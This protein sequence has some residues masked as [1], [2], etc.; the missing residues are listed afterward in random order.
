M[1][2][3]LRPLHEEQLRD[4]IKE[5]YKNRIPLDLRGY[6]SKQELG[7]P[8]HADLAIAMDRMRSIT[9]YRPDEMI[10][11]ALAGTPL[12]FIEHRLYHENQELAF[13]PVD[14][15]PA[16]GKVAGQTSIGAVF[17]M[18]MSGSRRIRAGAARDHLIGVRGLN[19]K[20]DMINSGGKVLKNVAGMDMAKILCGSW[21]TLALFTEVTMRVVPK[22]EESR[23]LFIEGLDESLGVSALTASINSPHEVTGTLHLQ[24]GFVS[25]LSSDELNNSDKSL[26][27]IRLEGFSSAVKYHAAQLK[28]ELAPFGDIYEF[29]DTRSRNFWEEIRTFKY[30]ESSDDPVWRLSVAPSDGPVVIHHLKRDM[31][32]IAA[33]DWSGGLIWLEVSHSSDANAADIR[34]AIAKTGGH[35]TLIRAGEE[36]RRTVEVFQP[37]EPG[38][39]ELAS[40]IK[41]VFDPHQIFNPGRM[42][43]G[44]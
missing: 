3:I 28:K 9:H 1:E 14:F 15:G 8:G 5:A 26:T 36:T 31:D 2:E 23:T 13:E 20:G 10:I 21:G 18:N 38:Q 41:N 25:R 29:D 24:P 39:E 22:A 40:Q 4:I 35:A 33:F 16:L 11:S 7:R 44:V 27:V 17:A 32:C 6:G 37:L 19:G 12:S 43:A 34:R 42:Y 30:L